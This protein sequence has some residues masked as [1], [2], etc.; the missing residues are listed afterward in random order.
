MDRKL[1]VLFLILRWISGKKPMNDLDC[2]VS[3]PRRRRRQQEQ[4]QP[5]ERRDAGGGGR[6]DG[7][8]PRHRPWPGPRPERQEPRRCRDCWME[9][10]SWPRGS[11]RTGRGWGPTSPGR[12]RTQSTSSR[13]STP[14]ALSGGWGGRWRRCPLHSRRS[15]CR[16]PGPAR[17]SCPRWP[18]RWGLVMLGKG[19][20]TSENIVVSDYSR[21]QCRYETLQS[22]FNHGNW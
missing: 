2:R 3:L 9:R 17:H 19:C 8:D 5:R 10:C 18:D 21:A 1:D 16:R 13:S 11:G 7:G 6:G 14:S 20:N 15:P 12:H 4:E 22:R